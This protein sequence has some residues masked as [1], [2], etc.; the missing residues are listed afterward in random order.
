MKNTQYFLFIALFA[1]LVAFSCSDG[2]TTDPGGGGDT[3]TTDTNTTTGVT[4]TTNYRVKTVVNSNFITNDSSWEVETTTYYYSTNDDK[5]ASSTNIDGS[6]Y[7][8][9]V[10]YT[11]GPNVETNKQY[12][13]SDDSF[14]Y[15]KVITY[16]T[17]G[18]VLTET[19]YSNEDCTGIS[20]TSTNS[21]DATYG[22]TNSISFYYDESTGEMVMS[23]EQTWMFTSATVLD[24]EMAMPG[25]MLYTGPTTLTAGVES[26]I[27][28]TNDDDDG[29]MMNGFTPNGRD[30]NDYVMQKVVIKQ[31]NLGDFDAYDYMNMY[32]YGGHDTWL[33]YEL[34]TNTYNSRDELTVSHSASYDDDGTTLK[35]HR[36][37]TYDY[38]AYTNVQ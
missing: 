37:K 8:N 13:S 34:S 38:E 6:D 28:M 24:F 26:V 14:N 20:Y 32:N 9:Y 10:L 1:L 2:G 22:K 18:D 21:Y 12:S 31:D 19:T 4:V 7:T 33:T 16:N 27:Y 17:S 23:M 25:M 29:N 5:K 30:T 15:A 11:Y 3:N 35:S 36:I